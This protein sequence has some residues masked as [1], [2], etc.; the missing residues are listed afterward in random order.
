MTLADYLRDGAARPFA[1]DACDC[2]SW[3]CA[4]VML[5]RGVDPS[6]PWRGRY[7]TARG[8]IRQIRR[9][10]GDFLDVVSKAMAAAGLVETSEPQS[11]DVGL[12]QTPAGLALAIRTPLGWAA[13]AERGIAAAPFRCLRAWS[14]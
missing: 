14:V 5:R 6:Q 2:C 8:A 1:W 13:K 12:V 3:A 9:A 4:W 7:R 10:G 11:G